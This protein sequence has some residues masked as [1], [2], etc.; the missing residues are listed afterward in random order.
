MPHDAMLGNRRGPDAPAGSASGY[1]F[2]A[3]YRYRKRFPLTAEQASSAVL[4]EFEGVYRDARI[5]TEGVRVTTPSIDPAQVRVD[6]DCTQ[7][8]P[9]ISVSD[10]SG[11]VVAN[12]VVESN[13]D[14]TLSAH[15]E[16]CALLGFGS[17]Q[18]APVESYLSGTFT[19]YRGR[20]M[21]VVRRSEPGRATLVVEG[22]VLGTVTAV[23][24]WDSSPC[25]Q[26]P[27]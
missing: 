20:A 4:L 14:E 10:E 1:F 19:T 3:S 23:V 13:A 8:S 25:P 12:G 16:G 5:A 6:V 22:A 15:V 24:E 18:R 26:R 17:A 21:A 7:G 27:A 9:R 11:A 2:G